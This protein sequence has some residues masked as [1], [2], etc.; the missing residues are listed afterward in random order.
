[1][2]S[3]TGSLAST[4]A[5][6]TRGVMISPAVRGPNSTERSISSAVSGSSVPSVGR[7]ADQRGELVGGARRAQLLLRLHAE[8]PHDRVGRPVEQPDRP[9]HHGG[10]PAHEALGARGRS[11]SARRWRGSSGTS[12]PKIIVSDG[13]RAPGRARRRSGVTAL[14]GHA[15][16]ASS[17]V[18]EQ[19]GDRGLGEEADRQVGHGDAD[20]GAGELGGQR[21]QRRT[22][23]L[24]PAVALG[25]RLLDRGAVDGHEGVLRRDEDAARE[26]QDHGDPEQ[27]PFHGPIVSGRA[28]RAT[29]GTPVGEP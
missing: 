13:R 19:V 18:V 12:S 29:S 16:R 17:G 5:I 8:A 28:S 1:M 14:V 10:E 11:P 20:L 27:Q 22:H 21:A 7:A 6:C 2:T 23:A 24:A 15:E 4:L 3:L 26:H 9:G 25:G